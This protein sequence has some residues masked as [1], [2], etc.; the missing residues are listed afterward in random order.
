MVTNR[1]RPGE[2]LGGESAS[3]HPRRLFATSDCALIFSREITFIA[4]ARLIA[5]I[6]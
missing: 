3:V 4:A 5:L 1:D 2:C 6:H